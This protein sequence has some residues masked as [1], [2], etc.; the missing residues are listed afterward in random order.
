MSVI[1]KRVGML[2]LMI[3]ISGVIVTYVGAFTEWTNDVYLYGISILIGA[4]GGI[5]L[6]ISGENI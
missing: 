4:F 2:S 1:L 5:L 6:Y 3:G